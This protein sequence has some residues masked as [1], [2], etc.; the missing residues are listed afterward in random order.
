MAEQLP[1]ND[2]A[3]RAVLGAVLINNNAIETA[4]STLDVD[5]FF[6]DRNRR[7]YKAMLDLRIADQPIDESMLAET[8]GSD[9][10]RVGGLSYL[11]ELS[12]GLPRGDFV[13]RYATV[14][15][16]KSSLRRIINDANSVVTAAM[17]GAADELDE[18]VAA[19]Q[20]TVLSRKGAEPDFEAYDGRYIMRSLGIVF[21]VDY[22]RRERNQLVGELTV[23]R[24]DQTLSAA[25]FNLS[26]A[27]AR[28]ERARHLEQRTKMKKLDWGRLLEEF[29]QH[30]LGAERQGE[31]AVSLRDVPRPTADDEIVVDGVPLLPRHPVIWFG[32]G[33]TFKSYLALYFAGKMARRGRRIGYF[34]WE[35]DGGAHRHRLER[36]FG[37]DMPDIKY[38]RCEQPLFRMAE[39]VR[40]T[41]REERLDYAIFDSIAFACDGPPEAA[42]VASRYFGALRQLG[43]IGSLHIAH[44]S[45]SEGAD[46]KPFGSTFWANGARATWFM[47]KADA[48]PGGNQLTIGLYNRKSNLS[49]LSSPGGFGITFSSQRTSLKPVAI[50]NHPDLA[51]QLSVRHRMASALRNGSMST[52]DLADT[53]EAKPNTV[54]RTARRYRKQFTLLKGGKLGLQEGER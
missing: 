22:L 54:T 10:E 36:L 13:E 34:D 25:D 9:L 37:D 18:K 35:L 27:R 7:I 47:K 52:A 4:A 51:A 16:D 28:S 26:S 31:P 30:V 11:V 19:M 15:Q 17:N 42:E 39:H 24:G 12:V 46:R 49:G 33:G 43:P 23:C 53:I 44:I 40:R 1:H 21:T 50:E 45:K 38:L 2:D 48:E 3:E 5:D 6:A 29:A 41:V 8:L 14:V 20:A 32:D